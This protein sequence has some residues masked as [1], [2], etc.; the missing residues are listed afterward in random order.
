MRRHILNLSIASVLVVM[1]WH[2][3]YISSCEVSMLSDLAM[4]NIEALATGE[5]Q[6]CPDGCIPNGSGC[7]CNGWFSFCR[8]K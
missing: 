8:E 1:A 4:D 5:T 3:V 7:W 2:T 6:K